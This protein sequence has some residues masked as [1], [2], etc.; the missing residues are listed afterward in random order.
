MS[1]S[2]TSAR[3]KPARLRIPP[4]SSLGILSRRAFQA[5]LAQ[6]PV[7]DLL[8]LV[9]ALVGVL[10]Q[11]ERDVVPQVHRAEQRAVLEQDAE[12]LAHL[13]QLVVGH[14]GH[15]LAVHQH[16][17]LVGIQQPDH[18]L[19]AHRLPGA[20]R[21]R[22]SSRSCRPGC[23]CSGRAG[24]CCG[25]T[26]CGPRRTRRRPRSRAGAACP[27]ATGTRPRRRRRAGA[28]ASSRPRSSHPPM[29]ARG[30]APQKIW[31]PS[32]PMRCTS[33]MFSTMDFAVAVPTP[34]G[35]PLTP[36]SRSSSRPARSRW[37]WP[38]L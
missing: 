7:D 3:A 36:C 14:A 20:R 5:D 30:L 32:I 27:C 9:L 2:S 1:G 4:E 26:P 16:V 29:G 25:R 11:R 8:D 10:A 35:P 24:S 21:A 13:E 15:R 12:L 23:P 22:G 19:D 18:V 38:C 34:T 37:P 28:L 31:V 17:A 33:T 6:A